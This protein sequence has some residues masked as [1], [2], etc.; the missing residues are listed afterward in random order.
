MYETVSQTTY[1]TNLS[2]Y[3]AQ[4]LPSH[5]PSIPHRLIESRLEPDPFITYGPYPPPNFTSFG[6]HPGFYPDPSP[7]SP[8]IQPSASHG[9][10]PN[11]LI[12]QT[13]QVPRKKKINKPKAMS[14]NKSVSQS[15]WCNLC[16]IECNSAQL[17]EKHLSGK[18]HNKNL[19]LMY[20]STIVAAEQSSHS[21]N[22]AGEMG[23]SV[24]QGVLGVSS[25]PANLETKKQKLLEGGTAA[26]SLRVCTIC[27]VACNGEI[28][29]S[30]H[31]V[32]RRHI[33]QER[34][35]LTR[36]NSSTTPASNPGTKSQ[37][38]TVVGAVWCEICK[39]S[40]TSNDGLAIHR[41][42]KK[43]KKNLENLRKSISDTTGS[44][45]SSTTPV[46]PISMP[47]AVVDN[48]E[49]VQGLVP[50]PEPVKKK[51]ARSMEPKDLETKKQ[52]ILEAGTP[53][54]AVK[55]CSICNVVCNSETVFSTHLAG[56]KHISMVKRAEAEAPNNL[57]VST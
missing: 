32:G 35:L 42:G 19:K 52:K 27:N 49:V 46:G 1:T 11:N 8:A 36:T 45:S 55:T 53:A 3:S 25:V 39:I 57:L 38:T 54:D 4:Q 17:Y 30:E 48:P 56:Q 15:V 50:E 37:K 43:H 10:Y 21:G 23:A 13:P 12:G 34:A 33:A 31:L 22:N 14:K 26:Q 20:D 18:K 51:G 40:C 29:F 7:F 47:T 44:L 16:K 6:P 24:G 9:T 5:I 2:Y 41:Q 28:V